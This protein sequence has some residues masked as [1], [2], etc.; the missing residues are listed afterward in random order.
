MI[1]QTGVFLALGALFLISGLLIRKPLARI[2]GTLGA[3]I[4]LG[5][6]VMTIFLGEMSLWKSSVVWIFAIVV[7]LLWLLFTRWYLKKAMNT[8]P[9]LIETERKAI[10]GSI[11]G[12]V[13]FLIMGLVGEVRHSDTLRIFWLLGIVNFLGALWYFW[14]IRTLQKGKRI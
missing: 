8:D 12:G 7:G 2:T 4:F 9:A 10:P 6:G 3:V 13:V 14:N 11:L 1:S 5:I